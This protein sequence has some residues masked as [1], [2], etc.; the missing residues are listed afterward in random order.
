MHA[1]AE[2]LVWI[3]VHPHFVTI[4]CIAKIMMYLFGFLLW[5]VC[6]VDLYLETKEYKLIYCEIGYGELFYNLLCSYYLW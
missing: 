2:H 6:S 1:V 3:F 5:F 4:V